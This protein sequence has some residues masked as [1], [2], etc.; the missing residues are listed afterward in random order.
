MK[1]FLAAVASLALVGA[2]QAQSIT[3]TC[4]WGVPNDANADKGKFQFMCGN[5][6]NASGFRDGP[7]REEYVSA[8]VQQLNQTTASCAPTDKECI[9]Q[10]Y[11][12][13][14]APMKAKCNELSRR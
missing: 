10:G 2:A 1:R 3:V 5:F 12:Q 8:C 11:R 13:S 6:A 4:S 7:K 9:K 14:E